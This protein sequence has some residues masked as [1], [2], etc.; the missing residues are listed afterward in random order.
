MWKTIIIAALSG[1]LSGKMTAVL[2]PKL[3]Y[4]EQ[5]LLLGR[6]QSGNEC[7]KIMLTRMSFGMLLAVLH[8]YLSP[9]PPFH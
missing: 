9:S 6:R 5:S 7:D 2:V 1:C 4:F 3:E 8:C